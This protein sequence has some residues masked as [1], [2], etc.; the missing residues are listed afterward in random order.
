MVS[1]YCHPH[2]PAGYR[3]WL[4]ITVTHISLYRPWLVITVTH[5][6]LFRLWLVI[7]VTYI[8]L[9]RPWLVITSLTSPCR[10]QAVVSYYCH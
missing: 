10:L 7:T 3:P 6:S 4:V 9:Y 8:S 5:I 1:Y 2:L